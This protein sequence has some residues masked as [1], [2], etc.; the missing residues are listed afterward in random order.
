MF[1]YPDQTL[2]NWFAFTKRRIIELLLIT[3]P[4]LLSY[5]FNGLCIHK[6]GDHRTI[7]S[8]R[9]ISIKLIFQWTIIN[10]EACIVYTRTYKF[11]PINSTHI[12][13][14]N[15]RENGTGTHSYTPVSCIRLFLLE[16][17]PVKN[18]ESIY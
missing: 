16:D 17:S 14:I 18:I 5:F 2:Q 12:H 10:Q 3:D 11:N 7:V 9:P 1:T 4:C 15:I 6:G 13:V 8:Y